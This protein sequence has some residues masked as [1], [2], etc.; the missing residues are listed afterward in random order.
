MA[1]HAGFRPVD[2]SDVMRIFQ[3]S[4]CNRPG[5]GRVTASAAPPATEAPEEREKMMRSVTAAPKNPVYNRGECKEVIE[6]GGR[7]IYIL[8]K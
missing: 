8:G 2:F 3:C 5:T 7:K 6:S 1:T 4:A